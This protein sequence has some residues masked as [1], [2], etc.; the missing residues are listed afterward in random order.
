MMKMLIKSIPQ[1]TIESALEKIP[2]GLDMIAKEYNQE[3]IFLMIRKKKV[4]V[5]ETEVKELAFL[6]IMHNNNGSLAVVEKDGQK[7][8]YP[9]DRDKLQLLL[10][11]FNGSNQEEDD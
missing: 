1:K 9:I 8:E 7:A 5:S 6:V 11:M 4:F 10:N 2:L 3:E